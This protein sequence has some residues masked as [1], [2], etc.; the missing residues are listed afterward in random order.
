[1]T[2]TLQRD[3]PEMV[4]FEGEDPTGKTSPQEAVDVPG[5]APTSRSPWRVIKGAVSII[6]GAI[7][8]I[9]AVLAIVVAVSTHFSGDG[10]LGVFG[11][12]VM[13]VL[14]GSMAPKINTGDLVI[15][16]KLSPAQAADLHV[17]QIISFRSAANSHQIFTHRIA[18]VETLPG[19]TVAYV[20]K[21]DA[22]ASRDVPLAASTSVVGRYESKVPDGGYLLN[23][24]HQPL[25]LALILASPIL[26]LLSE[27][28]WKWARQTEEAA[29]P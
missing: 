6:A 15:E 5:A 18:A 17:G 16:D 21:G 24:L 26:W 10:Q 23:A 20:T 22:N 9:V 12:P 25:V 13:T 14:S 19:G 8:A 4:E 27:P 28:L 29:T 11:H 2:R 3:R 1:M 7:L